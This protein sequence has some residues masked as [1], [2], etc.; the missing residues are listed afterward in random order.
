MNAAAR[1]APGVPVRRPSIES[2]ASAVR[3][4]RTSA[5]RT[6]AAGVGAGA[7]ACRAHPAI[8]I[9]TATARSLERGIIS[10]WSR[11][12]PGEDETMRVRVSVC[13]RSETQMTQ[14]VTDVTD[15]CPLLQR[16]PLKKIVA[17]W[18]IS[19][20]WGNPQLQV[21]FFLRRGSRGKGHVSMPL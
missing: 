2:C 15:D 3:M 1:S 20:L 7:G 4:R 14:M 8:A 19:V 9:A 16:L 5:A 17:A 10:L 12:H 21:F 18:G 13:Q 6:T 11:F